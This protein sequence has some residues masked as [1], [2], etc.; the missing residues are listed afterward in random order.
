MFSHGFE[1]KPKEEE[2]FNTFDAID[3]NQIR[4]YDEY[5]FESQ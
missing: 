2:S 5:I 1:R 3:V 4:K